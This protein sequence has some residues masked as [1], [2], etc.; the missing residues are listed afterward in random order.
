MQQNGSAGMF[1]HHVRLTLFIYANQIVNT[2][3]QADKRTALSQFMQHV[4][5]F[6]GDSRAT[7]L[8]VL[9]AMLNPKCPPNFQLYQRATAYPALAS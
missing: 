2:P 9:L 7:G 1:L 4:V 8:T 6:F 3:P 5:A